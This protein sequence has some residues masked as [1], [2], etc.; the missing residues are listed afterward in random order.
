[1][2]GERFSREEVVQMVLVLVG[3]GLSTT[4][5]LIGNTIVALE[6]F[7]AAKARFLSD[8][9]GLAEAVVEEGL[10]YDGPIHGLFRTVTAPVEL[11]GRPLA[12]GERVFACYSAANHDPDRFERPDEFVL[13]RDWRALP[14]HMAFGYGIHH[15]AGAHLARLEA[16]V[17]I[18]TL[19]RRL[20]G[21]RLADGFV[22]A[23]LS[24]AVF[25]GWPEVR[26]RFCPAPVTVPQPV[27]LHGPVPG[28]APVPVQGAVSVQVHRP[29]H[30]PQGGGAPKAG[31]SV[32]GFPGGGPTCAGLAFP[33]VTTDRALGETA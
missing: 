29:V 25:R 15:C 3:A 7:P 16:Q 28:H 11:Q 33:A 9:D 27:P 21:L 12:P 30:V 19:Y 1:V 14:P 13:D 2:D 24:G 18:A 22:P 6:S 5:T 26:M 10:R 23:Q 20:P 4:A 32:R 8:V 31:G 17:A